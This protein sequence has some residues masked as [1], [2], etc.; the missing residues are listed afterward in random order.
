MLIASSNIFAAVA[1][2][3]ARHKGHTSSTPALRSSSTH[4]A[5]KRCEHGSA[6]EGESERSSKQ[7]AHSLSGSRSSAGAPEEALEG[8][9]QEA[10]QDPGGAER[11]Q[12]QG[13]SS[14]IFF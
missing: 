7:M 8:W 2:S 12:G 1:G 5:W 11:G 6:G 3:F 4:D 10:V 14:R 9:T 13:R